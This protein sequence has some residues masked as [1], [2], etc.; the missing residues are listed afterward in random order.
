MVASDTDLRLPLLGWASDLF[1]RI[2]SRATTNLGEITRSKS[3]IEAYKY[4]IMEHELPGASPFFLGQLQ[5]Y[6]IAPAAEQRFVVVGAVAAAYHT[7]PRILTRRIVNRS[8]RLMS[9]LAT[10]AYV[11]KKDL[12]S[13]QPEVDHRQRILALLAILNSSLMSFLYISRS[14]SATKD[15]FRQVTLSGLRELPIIFPSDDTEEAELASLARARSNQQPDKG[16]ALD[17]QIDQIVYRTY[18]VD[19][20]EQAAIEEWLA[21]SG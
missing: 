20:S 1:H 19:E 15:D 5:R 2:A 18:G 12:Y 8:N 13:I 10:D 6:D 11:V 16:D 4:S 9:A 21:R 17:R 14:A 7:G 3:G